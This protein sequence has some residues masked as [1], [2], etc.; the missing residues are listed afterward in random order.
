MRGVLLLFAADAGRGGERSMSLDDFL[1]VV[2]RPLKQRQ[3]QKVK[4]QVSI[5]GD[6]LK[7]NS[8]TI[9]R[10]RWSLFAHWHPV[11]ESGDVYTRFQT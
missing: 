5:K 7:T 10:G 2:I 8:K 3:Q 6:I 4:C 9:L 11:L 1:R